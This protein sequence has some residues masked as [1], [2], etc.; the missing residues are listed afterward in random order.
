MRSSGT[1]SLLLA[2]LITVGC[3]AGPAAAP[4]AT[5]AGEPEASSPPP[6]HEVFLGTLWVQTSAEYEALAEQAYAAAAARLEEALAD[7]SW[8]AALEQEGADFSHL[9]PAVILD[10][11]ETVLD[12]ASFEAGLVVKNAEYSESLWEEWVRLEQATPV[13]G[14][15]AF[16]EHA[17]EQGVTI[18]Y[19]TNR[20]AGQEEATRANL[21]KEGFPIEE[22]RDVVFMKGEN[23][24]G[25]DKTTRR[26][27]V[28]KT[29]RILLLFGDDLN[30]FV[31]GAR[32]EAPEPRV[33]LARD[34][35]GKWGHRWIVLPNP[36]YGSWEASLFGRNYAL[37]TADKQRLKRGYLRPPT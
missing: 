3:S 22:S 7:P 32:A 24:W 28:A 27:E 33:D 31:S 8:T 14:A 2:G 19:V 10:V 25:S 1:L 26:A 5:P 30:D 15:K 37:P 13:P 21:L 23:D 4:V 20:S 35:A 6:V 29:H 18:F 9:P 34:H 17:H 36:L 16:L 11:D 12:N